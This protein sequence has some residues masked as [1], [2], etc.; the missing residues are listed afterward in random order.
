MMGIASWLAV[1]LGGVLLAGLFY[2]QI[3]LAEGAYLGKRTVVW[4]YDRYAPRY[5]QIKGF[6]E[7]NEAYFLGQP[8]ARA[9]LSVPIPLVLD[10]ATGTGRLPLVLLRQPAFRGRIVGLELSRRMIALAAT[11]LVDW[12]DRLTLIWQ[13][14]Q[15]LPFPDD[16]FDAV[17]CL[18]TLEFLPDASA[19]LVEM[20]RVLRPGGLLLTTNRVGP[21]ARFLPGRALG[22]EDFVAWLGA[23]SLTDVQVVA[24]QV[25]YDL[26]WARKPGRSTQAAPA[27]LPELLR[28]PRCTGHPLAR[29]EGAFRCPGCGRIYPVAA[30]GVVEMAG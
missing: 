15:M 20:V 21:V 1:A 22:R 30:D 14:A 23:H 29:R 13:D 9:L 19:A 5:D 8:L 2:W 25:D 3:K 18:E 12:R 16:A 6:H 4:L 10:V 11:K 27:T 24:W 28:C 7:G 26:A 17:T